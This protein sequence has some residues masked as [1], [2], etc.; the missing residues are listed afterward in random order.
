[1]GTFIKG[2]GSSTSKCCGCGGRGPCGGPPESLLVC[3]TAEASITKCGFNEWSGYV[4]SPPRIYL[5]KTLGGSITAE[6]GADNCAICNS[7][8]QYVYSG[9]LEITKASCPTISSDTTQLVTYNYTLD[10]INITTINVNSGSQ[11]ISTGSATFPD[12]YTSTV[13]TITGVGCLGGGIGTPSND[14]YGS[15]TETLSNEWTTAELETDVAN[16]IPAYSGPFLSGVYC[17]GGYYDKTT[18]ELTITKRKMVYKFNL[19]NFLG[20]S[21]LTGYS[22][23]KIMWDEIFTPKGGGATTTTSQSYV[24]DGSATETPTYEINV[25]TLQGT[26]IVDN[27]SYSCTCP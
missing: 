12:T 11:S 5:K 21:L 25:P 3:R 10:C 1:M 14:F 8:V 24:W 26:T 19:P 18:D 16:A 15:A 6:I 23:Y 4:S 20:V 22:C 27:I 2:T 9:Y 13:H 7:K 17:S